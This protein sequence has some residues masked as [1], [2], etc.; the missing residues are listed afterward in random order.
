MCR[1]AK[2]QRTN[3]RLSSTAGMLTK[4][5]FFA[6]RACLHACMH[7][8]LETKSLLAQS[9]TL[10]LS[11]HGKS[12]TMATCRAG[13]SHESCLPELNSTPDLLTKSLLRRIPQLFRVKDLP[14]MY[15]DTVTSPHGQKP[16]ACLTCNMSDPPPASFASKTSTPLVKGVE[17]EDVF[18][19]SCALSPHA[20][21]ANLGG[22]LAS[23]ITRKEFLTRPS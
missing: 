22:Y 8:H 10:C 15:P 2:P 23:G 12:E 18:L 6:M 21:C 11:Q 14:H 1:S 16:D 5:S 7:Q 13:L 19:I 4:Q 3:L 17:K 20:V 9:Y